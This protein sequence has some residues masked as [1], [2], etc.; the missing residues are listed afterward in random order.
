MV[1]IA[2]LYI[3]MGFFGYLKYGADTAASITL[4]L[5]L[6][7]HLGPVCPLHVQYCHLLLLC[8]PVLC[9]DGHNWSKH[10]QAKCLGQDVSF[11][12]VAHQ[13]PSQCPN[14][15]NGSNCTLAVP[16]GP[17]LGRLCSPLEL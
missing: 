4:N 7:R 11:R 8:S 6:R 12:G 1:T 5:P 15:G 14:F 17:C 9:C 3:G 10:N 2:A 13:S 16:D